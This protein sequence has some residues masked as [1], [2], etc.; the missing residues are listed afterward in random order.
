VHL[1][2]DQQIKLEK[3]KNLLEGDSIENLNR[4][5]RYKSEGVRLDNWPLLVGEIIVSDPNR[6][7]KKQ[8]EGSAVLEWLSIHKPQLRKHDCTIICQEL[9][10]EQLLKRDGKD[11]VKYNPSH[12]Y[13]FILSQ[14]GFLEAKV[15]NL[16]FTPPSK[17]LEIDFS[18]FPVNVFAKQL[19]YFEWA[20]FQRIEL[21]EI[22][23]WLKGDKDKR[24]KCAPNLLTLTTFVNRVSHWVITEII[25]CANLKHRQ[26]LLKKFINIA[27]HCFEYK[28]YTGVL[29]IVLGLHHAA[30]T[31]MKLTW[32]IPQNY[33]TLFETMYKVVSPEN[34]WKH[35]RKLI[36]ESSDSGYIPYI[37]L[38]LADLTFIK[39]GGGDTVEVPPSYGV[40]HGWTK[41]RSLCN[42]LC[43]FL[44]LQEKNLIKRLSPIWNIKTISLSCLL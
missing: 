25:T 3:F 8:V 19:T 9:I 18:D 40:H 29:E 10:S 33:I 4:L 21:R 28:N 41:S 22:L 1:S 27:A 31:R 34:N 7:Y 16:V 2:S 26:S 39:D 35:W 6:F 11:D 43:N 37:G 36:S 17:P 15:R 44:F 12:K 5:V 14:A 30:I 42:K 20:L 23:Y 24:E 13:K 32:K 38:I